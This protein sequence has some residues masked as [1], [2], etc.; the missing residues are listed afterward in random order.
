MFAVRA[1]Y[2]TTLQA[3]P[4]QLVFGRDAI[5]NTKFEANWKYIQQ[6][7]QAIINKNNA[8]ENKSRQQYQ[9]RVG[10]QVLVKEDQSR[11]Y[12]KNPYSGPYTV[13]Q[14][15]NNGSIRLPK[16]AVQQTYN[17]RNLH[18]FRDT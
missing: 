2:H 16:G 9:Y 7:K 17:V 8:A 15:N 11:K 5:L 1:T 10:H 14:I 18:P 4:S 13:V 12:G 3:T 6:R